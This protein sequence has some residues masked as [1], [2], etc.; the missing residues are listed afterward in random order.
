MTKGNR[1]FLGI[2]NKDGASGMSFRVQTHTLVRGREW[3][4]S[5]Q[6]LVNGVLRNSSTPVAVHSPHF[7]EQIM[8][9]YAETQCIRAD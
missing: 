4:P 8:F 9:S 6:P 1:C 3:G 2:N 5:L 7:G